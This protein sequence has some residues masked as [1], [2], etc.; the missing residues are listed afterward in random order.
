[1]PKTSTTTTTGK[2]KSSTL[3]DV[4][5]KKKLDKDEFKV[6]PLDEEADEDLQNDYEMEEG[7]IDIEYEPVRMPKMHVSSV[8]KG[9]EI[10]NDK[11]MKV[12]SEDEKAVEAIPEPKDVIKVKFGSFVNLVANHELQ[13]VIAA[14]ANEDI[15]MNSTLLTELASAKDQREER[16]IPLVFLVGIA[17]GVVLTYIFFST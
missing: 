16:K 14:N 6:T 15:I 7:K 8:P 4:S 1:M 2:K 5:P 9:G 11:T 17:I 13:D 3:R 10:T 12:A